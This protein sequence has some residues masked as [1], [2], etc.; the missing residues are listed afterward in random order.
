MVKIVLSEVKFQDVSTKRL[1][2][3]IGN[4]VGQHYSER[5][6]SSL[7][8]KCMDWMEIYRNK[9]TKSQPKE[10][11]EINVGTGGWPKESNFYGHRVKVVPARSLILYTFPNRNERGRLTGLFAISIARYSS[12]SN[13]IIP[14]QLIDL[15]QWCSLNPYKTVDRKIYNLF[16]NHDMYILAYNKI[17]SNPG[18][19]TSGIISK[20]LNGLSNKWI[21]ETIKSLKD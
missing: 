20:T 1:Y 19:L 4:R 14:K 6:V 8:T 2:H 12:G 10:S 3:F 17:K 7:Y 13:D 11:I 21:M 16:F 9:E 5:N 18:N 15:T